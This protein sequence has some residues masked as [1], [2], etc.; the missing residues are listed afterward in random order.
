LTRRK[1]GRGW[2]FLDETGRPIRDRETLQRIRNLVIPPAWSRVWICPS[3][4]GHLQAVGYDARG[5]KQY[6]YHSDYSALRNA[7][8]FGRMAEF[9]ALLPR[10]RER[11]QSDLAK[12]GLPREKVLAAVVRLLETTCIRVGNEEYARQNKSFG[13][14][15]MQDRHVDINGSTVRFHFRGKSGQEHEIKLHDRRLARIVHECQDL[16]GCE[17]FQYIGEDGARHGIDSGDVNLYIA[18]IGAPGFTAKDFRTWAGTV[19]MATA[20]AEC[21]AADSATQCKKRIVEAVKQVAANLGNRPATCRKYY[22]H[23][24]ILEFYEKGTLF[25]FMK[26]ED[27]EECVLG[28]L[29]KLA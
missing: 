6:R 18:E 5:R 13:L 25:E 20:L 21:G 7:T 24:A 4:N 12:H 11:V 28:L 29:K 9:G 16:P 23:P 19:Q 17:L 1:T 10:I 22:V 8:K 2:C 27:R 26:K 3:P 15:T 14:T